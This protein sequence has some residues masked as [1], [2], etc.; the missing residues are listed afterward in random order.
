[1]CN[2]YVT[3]LWQDGDMKANKLHSL[4]KKWINVLRLQHWDIKY[5]VLPDKEYQEVAITAGYPQGTTAGLNAI[6]K[7]RLHSIIYL[8][9]KELG[10]IEEYLVH[11]LVHLYTEGIGDLCNRLIELAANEESKSVL[12]SVASDELETLV[13]QITRLAL[14]LERKGAK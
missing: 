11:E 4:F 8:N 10:E 3:V 1:M 6:T 7:E 12:R 13:W 9:H 14:A 5:T 2:Q